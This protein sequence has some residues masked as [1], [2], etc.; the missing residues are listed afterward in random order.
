MRAV[1]VAICALTLSPL[2][3]GQIPPKPAPTD[4]DRTDGGVKVP[5]WKARL[6]EPNGTIQDLSFITMGFGMHVTTGPAAIL[7]NPDHTVTGHYTVSASFGPG[8]LP[9]H[10]EAYGLFI[11]GADL[12]TERQKYTC[13][14][15]SKDG[16]FLIKKRSGAQIKNRSGDWVEHPAIHK[17]D[18]SGKLTNQLAIRVGREVVSFV[19]NG[20]EVARHPGSSLDTSGIVGIR[21][22]H[23]IDMH[24][25]GFRVR[26][27][28]E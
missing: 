1:M 28:S 8:S 13:F 24:I 12:Q 7:W 17:F 25:D 15:V 23:H 3:A 20:Q 5:G 27:G 21:A 4:H 6:D 9:D 16:Q 10:Q 18:P 22:N 26:R 2:V 19:V 11:G 14:V